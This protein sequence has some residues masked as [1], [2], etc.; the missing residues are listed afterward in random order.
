MKFYEFNGIL[1][2]STNRR[3]VKIDFV[4]CKDVGEEEFECDG[5]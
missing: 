5:E 2:T 1:H 3:T 4:V